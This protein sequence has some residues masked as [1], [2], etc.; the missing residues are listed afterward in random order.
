MLRKL[1][2]LLF[3]VCA[4]TA[5]A[6]K[7]TKS[8][9]AKTKE[10]ESKQGTEEI[11]YKQ[12][13]SPMPSLVFLPFYDSA[14]KVPKNQRKKMMTNKDFDNDANLI[15]MMFNPTCGH[16]QEQTLMMGRSD[17]WF[18]KT[19]VVLLATLTMKPYLQDFATFTEPSAHSYMHLG[20]DSTDFIN[21]IFLYQSL[22]QIN[23]YD[24]ERKLLK[25]YTS[26][27]PMDTLKQFIE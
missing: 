7:K 12:V 9:P 1:F 2:V 21:N 26:N 11:D 17:E 3:A 24:H 18:K 19:K 22:P 5:I 27:V 4:V 10:T 16:C 6:Q 23:I 8:R 13:G 25:T 14:S 15:V 20:V